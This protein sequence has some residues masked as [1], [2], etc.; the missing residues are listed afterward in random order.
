M[1]R[2]AAGFTGT[3]ARMGK[4]YPGAPHYPADMKTPLVFSALP[5]DIARDA[6]PLFAEAGV[7]VCSN[8]SA[9][10]K[11]VDV[12]I[13]LPEVNA[14]HAK[15]SA[16]NKKNRGWKGTSPPTPTVQHGLTVTLKALQDAFGLERLFAVSLQA[17]SGAG[18]PGV[19]SMDIIDNV[20][21]FI[22][23]KKKKLS[24]KPVKCW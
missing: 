4:G 20:I 11:E 16:N 23:E 19:P 9:Y 24:G 10:R 2:Y 18:Y 12:P 13:L 14:D 3:H 8:A 7:A 17:L 5:A 1:L 6:E 15:L 21:P 22:A